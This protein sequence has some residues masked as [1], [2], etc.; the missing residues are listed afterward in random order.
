M[1]RVLSCSV[2][3][4]AHIRDDLPCQDNSDHD[5]DL[6]MVVV[7]D[8]HGSARHDKSEHGSRLAVE[9]ALEIIR[10]QTAEKN[11]DKDFLNKLKNDFPRLI[12]KS[13]RA[14]VDEHEAQ[15]RDTKDPDGTDSNSEKKYIRYGT[16]IIVAF[17]YESQLFLAQLGDGDIL[18]V[19][20]DG[21][22]RGVRQP[23]D[24]RIGDSTESLCQGDAEEA[25][26]WNI[27]VLSFGGNAEEEIE[28]CPTYKMVLICSDG[29]S[30]AFKKEKDFEQLASD[31]Y[32]MCKEKGFSWVEGKCE[33]WLEI[34]AQNTGDDASIGIILSDEDERDDSRGEFSVEVA[35]GEKF[36]GRKT[37]SDVGDE[38]IVSFEEFVSKEFVSEEFVSEEFVSEELVSEELVSEDP[39]SEDPVSED[40]VSEDSV[41]EDSVSSRKSKWSWLPKGWKI[42]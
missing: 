27:Q 42:D 7:A 38:K 15:P 3:G 18:V 21:N 24:L 14:D 25:K 22:V 40:S 30:N 23:G 17:V 31:I 36:S 26:N 20:S 37:S 32:G 35:N 28:G 10:K 33:E 13:W 5:S 34:Y 4:M 29:V 39:V 19:D 9:R 41:S 2:R 1:L 8:G 11:L 16:T 6:T 12:V